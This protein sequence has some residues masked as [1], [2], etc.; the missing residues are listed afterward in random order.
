MDVK[1]AYRAF[2]PLT[3]AIRR[4]KGRYEALI[5]EFAIWAEAHSQVRVWTE[6]EKLV[7]GYIQ[8][9]AVALSRHDY[10]KVRF[11]NPVPREEWEKWRRG[12]IYKTAIEVHVT[13]AKMPYKKVRPLPDIR[14]FISIDEPFVRQRDVQL[15]PIGA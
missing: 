9:Q 12:E 8:S 10:R 5:K 1:G 11:G 6:L 14:E 2:G 7:A 15:S 3:I 13:Q 4:R